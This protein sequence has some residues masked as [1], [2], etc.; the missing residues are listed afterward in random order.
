MI[1]SAVLRAARKATDM[2]QDDLGDKVGVSGQYIGKLERGEAKNPSREIIERIS[3]VLDIPFE[4]LL[5]GDDAKEGLG[6]PEVMVARGYRDALMKNQLA[7][8][9][10]LLKDKEER[11]K[12]TAL[13]EAIHD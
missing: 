12:L 10:I 8:F 3:K 1:A 9:A 7:I 5:L 2:N 4:S 6:E 13:A 11:E